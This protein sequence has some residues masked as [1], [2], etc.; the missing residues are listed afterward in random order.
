MP[1]GVQPWRTTHQQ[2]RDE[3]KTKGSH[4]RPDTHIARPRAQRLRAG[5][6]R[7]WVQAS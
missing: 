4:T 7:R 3:E 2:T 6:R 5:V 1:L